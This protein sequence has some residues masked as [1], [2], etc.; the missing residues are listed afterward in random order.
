M[1][2]A[3]LLHSVPVQNKAYSGRVGTIYN[4]GS[5]AGIPGSWTNN[6]YGVAPDIAVDDVVVYPQNSRH[7]VPGEN[8]EVTYFTKEAGGMHRPGQSEICFDLKLKFSVT[9]A[10]F[11]SYNTAGIEV[12]CLRWRNAILPTIESLF[13]NIKIRLDFKDNAFTIFRPYLWTGIMK[14][15]SYHPSEEHQDELNLSEFVDIWLTDD[16]RDRKVPNAPFFFQVE[17]KAA[18]TTNNFDIT[19]PVR[20]RITDPI[21]N[22]T[23]KAFPLG[24]MKQASIILTL[25]SSNRISDLFCLDGYKIQRFKPY[26]APERKIDG[27]VVNDEL[28]VVDEVGEPQARLPAQTVQMTPAEI[29]GKLSA[30][31]GSWSIENLRLSYIREDP[32]AMYMDTLKA[33]YQEGSGGYKIPYSVTHL[34]NTGTPARDKDYHR[35]YETDCCQALGFF[36]VYPWNKKDSTKALTNRTTL[37]APGISRYQM[38]IDGTP[39]SQYAYETKD[40]SLVLDRTTKAINQYNPYAGYRRFRAQEWGENAVYAVSTVGVVDADFILNGKK[41]VNAIDIL[42]ECNGEGPNNT[43]NQYWNQVPYKEWSDEDQNKLQ[44]FFFI[45][46]AGVLSITTSDAINMLTNTN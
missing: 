4:A 13:E 1:A 3:A 24:I 14:K 40:M 42:I 7:F 36:Y 44:M 16:V 17:E 33:S 29:A 27:N 35:S 37:H 31:E 28:K 26:I 32:G 12:F 22:G 41:I 25:Q 9:R 45:T 19:I 5:G 20:M 43:N 39:T 10:G 8:A 46:K 6:P 34:V 38:F 21:I 18:A 2:S 30:F 23:D 11:G 15:Y